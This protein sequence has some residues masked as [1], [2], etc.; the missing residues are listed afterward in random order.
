MRTFSGEPYGGIYIELNGFPVPNSTPLLA[1]NI[2]RISTA[3]SWSKTSTWSEK[4][5][6][7]M[8]YVRAGGEVDRSALSVS[9]QRSF[10]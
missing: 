2:R 1:A 10:W 5:L 4:S 8:L 6:R 9:T 7:P 3:T